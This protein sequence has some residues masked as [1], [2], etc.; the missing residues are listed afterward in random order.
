M[1]CE[2]VA[3]GP[4]ATR[5]QGRG[6]RPEDCRPTA[7][8]IPNERRCPFVLVNSDLV[9]ILG[10]ERLPFPHPVP[11]IR[12]ILAA[13]RDCFRGRASL[14]I[15]IIA[16]RHQLHVLER[17]VKRPK[18]T[19]S[20]RLF[21]ACLAA[22]WRSWRSALIMVKPV[23]ADPGSD[24]KDAGLPVAPERQIARPT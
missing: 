4:E 24:D 18:L 6:A 16:L 23:P 3:A 2:M 7:V 15:E 11:A 8:R 19:A 20:D 22:I 13:T 5:I 14:Q 17:S 9:E 10:V 21:W 1:T 12:A